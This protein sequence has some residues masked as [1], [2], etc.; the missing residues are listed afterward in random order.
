MR[1]CYDKLFQLLKEKGLKQADMERGA[2]ISR[3]I[4]CKMKKNEVI[5]MD[6]LI[7][8][9]LFLDCSF[10]DIVTIDGISH[11]NKRKK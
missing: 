9:C 10:D 1:I 8:I 3:N 6:K 11:S 4:T 2:N 5:A 7:D